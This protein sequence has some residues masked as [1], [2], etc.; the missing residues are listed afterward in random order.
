MFGMGREGAGMNQ[1]DTSVEVGLLDERIDRLLSSHLDAVRLL[2][3]ERQLFVDS[4]H[5]LQGIDHAIVRR[6]A[7]RAECVRCALKEL[8]VDSVM[9]AS[10]QDE[11]IALLVRLSLRD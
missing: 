4:P 11:T 5:L 8:D 3:D 9:S 1:H 2:Q 6:I 7:R 10:E